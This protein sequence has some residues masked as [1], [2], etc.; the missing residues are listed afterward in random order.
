MTVIVEP[1]N[2]EFAATVSGLDLS[3]PL[4]SQDV[5]DIRS[6]IHSY[7]VLVFREQTLTDE[8]QQQFSLN[9]GNLEDKRGGYIVAPEGERLSH[10]MND[11]SNLSKD[12][13]V[14]PRDNRQRL[15]NLGNR[16]WHSDS[17]YRA[18]PAKYSLLSGREV[19][20]NGGGNTEFSDMRAAYDALDEANKVE[21][22][23]LICEHSLIYSRGTLGFEV[24]E[25]EKEMFRPVRQRLVRTHPATG[26][27]SIYLSAHA[28]T[29]LGWPKAEAKI[30][31]LDMIEHA[32][33]RS[34][35]YSH[36][37]HK[38]DLVM[39]D[40]RC[41]MHR[42]RWFD[43]QQVRDMRRTTIAGDEMTVEQSVST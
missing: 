5:S 10:A 39:W 8:Q 16:L 38:N 37:W 12:N 9:F 3:R 21:I 4:S 7:A 13:T 33:Q 27:K 43:E 40:N 14:L 1:I 30:F 19:P 11:I 42:A 17:S 31:L 32:T 36:S 18:I 24:A 20:S 6:A 23:D 41:T 2:S 25:D 15:F 26:R 35:V 34:F 28:G 22:E 29:I